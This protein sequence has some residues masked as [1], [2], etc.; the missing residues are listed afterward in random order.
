VATYLFYKKFPKWLGFCLH[1]ISAGAHNLPYRYPS[2]EKD[3]RHPLGQIG[4]AGKHKCTGGMDPVESGLVACVR[5]SRAPV[6][7]YDISRNREK[8][9]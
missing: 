9:S 3:L 2:E 6:Y 8:A 4:S 5:H 1:T 7:D